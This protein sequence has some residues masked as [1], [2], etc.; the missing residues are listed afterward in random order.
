MPPKEKDI[1]YLELQWTSAKEEA[2]KEK[3]AEKIREALSEQKKK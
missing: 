2:E 3:R 1:F